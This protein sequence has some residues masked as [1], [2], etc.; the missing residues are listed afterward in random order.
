MTV[1]SQNEPVYPDARGATGQ[2]DLSD[3]QPISYA[4]H[5][6]ENINGLTRIARKYPQREV[7]A[8]INPSDV[9]FFGYPEC[10]LTNVSLTR[11]DLSHR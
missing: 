7:K 4:S 9:V 5:I 8:E 6:D 1:G 11:H 3:M 2:S 10:D